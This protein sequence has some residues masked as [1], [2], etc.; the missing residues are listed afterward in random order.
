MRENQK[1][2]SIRNFKKW[3]YFWFIWIDCWLQDHWFGGRFETI[4][5]HL[6]R[7]QREFGGSIPW[8]KRPLQALVSRFL[9]WLE[10]GHCQKGL[11]D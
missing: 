4:S 11:K 8:S 10:P 9:D 2:P 3:I 6:G 7:T 5:G 1:A